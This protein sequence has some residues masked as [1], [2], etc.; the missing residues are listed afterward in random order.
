[1]WTI[2]LATKTNTADS[3]IGNQSETRVI[4][5]D[6]GG[7]R[8]GTLPAGCDSV[9]AHTK[10]HTGSA[11]HHAGAEAPQLPGTRRLNLSG[12]GGG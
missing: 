8:R 2:E 12:A 5:M 1:M 11:T 7:V 9:N 6:V 10:S 4:I 3:R